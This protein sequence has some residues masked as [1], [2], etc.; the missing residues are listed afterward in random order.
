MS[1]EPLDEAGIATLSGELAALRGTSGLDLHTHIVAHSLIGRDERIVRAESGQA[2]EAYCLD[3]ATP[4]ALY[5]IRPD[6]YIAWRTD[7]LDVAA[8]REF[9]GRMTGAS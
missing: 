5:L 8:C 6:G 9:L 7:S 3:G 2:F 4:R 1:R